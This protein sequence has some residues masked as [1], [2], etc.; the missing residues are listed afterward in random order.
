MKLIQVR[1]VPDDVHRRLKV[2]AAEQGRTLS[3]LARGALSEY[4]ARP[5]MAEVLDRVRSREAIELPGG[6]AAAIREA[7][8]ER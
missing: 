6:A 1:N 2:R 3:D 5:T 8:S 4:A 7:R